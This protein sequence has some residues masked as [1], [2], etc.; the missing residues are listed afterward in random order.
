[1]K[2]IK[3]IKNPKAY[4]NVAFVKFRNHF[5]T[6]FYKGDNVYCQICNWKGRFFFNH[7]CPKCKSQERTRLVAYS[8]EYFN[9]IQSNLKILH[10][11]P[12]INEF[13]FVNHTFKNILVYD[14]LDI[15]KRK[16]INIV[17][18]ISSPKHVDITYDL[19]IVWHVF[20]HIKN[21][22]EAIAVLYKLL[23]SKGK[24]LVS[25]PIYPNQN[26]TTFEDDNIG[27]KDY[28]KIHGHYDHCRSCGLDYYL[29]FEK[30][31]FKTETLTVK[32]IKENDIN[33]YGLKKDHVVW[34]FKK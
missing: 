7:K 4:T 23:N 33:Y 5:R 8:L 31:G 22:L 29:R 9:L 21:D 30:R 20:E 15:K 27:Q 17:D 19:I 2:V 34:C 1:M 25:V 6:V 12:N 3:I 24:L 16:Q 11:A 28:H 14:R 26:K 13:N 32:S 10:I 18:D